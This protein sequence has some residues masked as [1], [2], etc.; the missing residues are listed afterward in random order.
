[1]G[2]LDNKIIELPDD[3]PEV[4]QV[5]LYWVYHNEICLRQGLLRRED[6]GSPTPN[7]KMAWGMLVKVYILAENYQM[8]RLRNNAI[9]AMLLLEG[10]WDPYDVDMISYVYE[11]TSRADCPLRRLMVRYA[12]YATL[13]GIL[14]SRSNIRNRLTIWSFDAKDFETNKDNFCPAFVFD[15]ALSFFRQ[16]DKAEEMHRHPETT[17]QRERMEPKD[18]FCDSFH[19][20]SGDDEE[21]TKLKKFTK[22]DNLEK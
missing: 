21:C 9:D 22:F 17:Q 16:L 4:V 8:R 10:D 7:M 11:H 12:H 14:I 6:N 20:H 13:T 2:E 1:M 3:D 19:E 5:I 18:K 15:V